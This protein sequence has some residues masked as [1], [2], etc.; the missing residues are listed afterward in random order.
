[1]TGTS[2]GEAGAAD[3]ERMIAVIGG[4]GFL[5]SHL[6]ERILAEG[7]GVDVVDDLS[8]GALANLAE[9]RRQGGA[10]KIHNFDITS[11][12]G[13]AVIAMRRPTVIYHLALFGDGRHPVDASTADRTF[14][15][16]LAVLEAARH[17]GADKVV[18]ALPA[19]ALYGK[20][21]ARQLPV[22]E[23]PLEARG[24]RG[25]VAKAV[26]DALVHYRDQYDL[27]FT[28]L[29]M[30]SVY[31]PG[32]RAD[33]GVVAR[34]VDAARREVPAEI[35]GDGRQTRDFLFVDDAID[36]LFKASQRGGGLVVNVGTGTQ[37][38]LRDLWSAVAPDGPDAVTSRP[39]PDDLARFAVSPVRARIQLAWSPWTALADGLAETIASVEAVG[40]HGVEDG[41]GQAG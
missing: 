26:V 15:S 27:E 33:A 24:L 13:L 29:A 38:S 41:G 5:G 20:P 7:H 14:G 9:A 22:K 25:V 6:V 28:A 23:L 40:G 30:C 17:A 21:S 12:D 37:T 11:D 8:T 32:Q 3:I 18:V 35:E 16:L 1:M 39:R 10:L 36:A 19:G 34:F 31:G 2:E 4:A